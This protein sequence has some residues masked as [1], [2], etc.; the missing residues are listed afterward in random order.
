VLLLLYTYCAIYY[1]THLV[2]SVS[3][4]FTSSL[5]T[6]SSGECSPSSGFLNYPVPQPKQF[7]ANSLTTTTFSRRLIIDLISTCHSR[8]R[9]LYKLN[10][11]VP[12]ENTIHNSSIVVPSNDYC[13]VVCLV[14]VYVTA[15]LHICMW[16]YILRAT[17]I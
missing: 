16:L 13:I 6:A 14:G 2:F 5:V 10:W 3:C 1:S 15:Y 12:Q 4:V 17:P 11:S 8:R 7:L 9:S